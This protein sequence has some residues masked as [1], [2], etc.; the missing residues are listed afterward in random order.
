MLANDQYATLY[1]ME[2]EQIKIG[3][4]LRD[5]LELRIDRGVYGTNGA[6]AYK[7]EWLRNVVERK[8]RIQ[9]LIDGRCILIVQQPVAG[10]FSIVT[11]EDITQRLRNETQIAFLA[12]RDGLTNLINRT[13]LFARLHTAIS[14]LAADE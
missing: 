10:G 12:T 1:G 6:S 3:M 13:A 14:S 5:V 8:V 9:D 7:R 11:H 2:P 4:T